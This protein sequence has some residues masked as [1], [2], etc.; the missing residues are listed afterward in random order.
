MISSLFER[1]TTY[2]LSSY[3]YLDIMSQSLKMLLAALAVVVVVV[4][5]YMVYQWQIGKNAEPA[6]VFSSEPATLPSGTST[7][8]DS[9]AQDA[10]AID[11]ELKGLE[12]DN[13]SLDTSLK[14]SAQVQ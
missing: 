8:D 4:A 9:L 5:G 3:L 13:T 7:T 1:Y 2:E 10:A 12:S 14:E 11:A 6:N